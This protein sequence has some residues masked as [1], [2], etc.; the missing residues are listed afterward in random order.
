MTLTIEISGQYNH[1][2]YYSNNM[3]YRSYFLSIQTSNLIIVT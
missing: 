3:I 1:S 2:Y